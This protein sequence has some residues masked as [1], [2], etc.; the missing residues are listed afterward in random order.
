MALGRSK[1]CAKKKI[2]PDPKTP[3]KRFEKSTIHKGGG[4]RSGAH[5]Q[6]TP[7]GRFRGGRAFRNR[8]RFKTR[9]SRRS[10][11]S[12]TKAT[13]SINI[14]SC[15]LGDSFRGVPP[16][17]TRKGRKYG[18]YQPQAVRLWFLFFAIQPY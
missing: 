2:L 3:E 4:I 14:N 1:V 17:Q 16:E 11:N 12:G 18:L 15:V 5:A 7:P 6:T 13:H 8:D 10:G 9:T